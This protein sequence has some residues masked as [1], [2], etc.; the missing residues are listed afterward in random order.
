MRFKSKIRSDKHMT[1][2][3]FRKYL[4]ELKLYGGK[5]NGINKIQ[6]RTE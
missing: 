4:E 5:K 3:D 1:D 2:K 6:S